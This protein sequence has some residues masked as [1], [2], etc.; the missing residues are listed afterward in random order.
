MT[1]LHARRSSRT[2]RFWMKLAGDADRYPVPDVPVAVVELAHGDDFSLCPPAD[3]REA[4][5]WVQSRPY[6]PEAITD[7]EAP[8]YIVET[9]GDW[10]MSSSPTAPRHV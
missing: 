9:N 8:M 3:A 4:L 7:G 1:S 5:A 10:Y 2:F 6:W